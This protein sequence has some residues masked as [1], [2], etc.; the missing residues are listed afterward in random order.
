MVWDFNLLKHISS[1][2]ENADVV[3]LIAEVDADCDLWDD[4]FFHIEKV[5]A[6]SWRDLNSFS[7]YLSPLRDLVFTKTRAEKVRVSLGARF[8][9]LRGSRGFWF[10]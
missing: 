9:G 3:S 2:I 1:L 7:F 8:G 10:R 4:V 5:I 6:I